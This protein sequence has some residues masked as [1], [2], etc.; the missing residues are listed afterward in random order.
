MKGFEDALERTLSHEGG[1]VNDPRDP[2]GETNWGISKRAYPNVDIRNLT[3]ESAAT[4][5]RRDYWLHAHCDEMPFALAY[6]VFDFAVNSG[7]GTAI[8]KLQSVLGL[9]D[10]GAYG[11]L[12]R[13][14]VREAD[15]QTTIEDLLD[16]RLLFMQ[17]LK[18]WDHFG[19]GWTNRIQQ[20]FKYAID[21][22]TNPS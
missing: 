5:Y 10:D 1:Y 11:P 21:D 15:V 4:L 2:G 19:R 18:G 13:Q 14:S 6:Q 16:A 22:V 20:N 12:T 8:R 9:A 3:R 7:V 17:H